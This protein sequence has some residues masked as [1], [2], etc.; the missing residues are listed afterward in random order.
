MTEVQR[1]RAALLK[2][3][4]GL[5]DELAHGHLG[6]YIPPTMEERIALLSQVA[7]DALG[8]P[9]VMDADRIRKGESL[10]QSRRRARKRAKRAEGR[11]DLS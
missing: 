3:A 8:H 6:D 2:V 9:S 10:R 5:R 11:S 7:W 1:L 4:E